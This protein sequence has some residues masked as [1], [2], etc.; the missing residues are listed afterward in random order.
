MALIKIN[1]NISYIPAVEE[2]LSCDV[3]FIKTNNATWI[4]D[5]GTNSEDFTEI[6]KIT[7][8][9]NIVISHFHYDHIFNLQKLDYT[10]L[11]VSKNTKKYSNDGVIVEGQMSFEN[12][13]EIKIVELPSS[14]AKGCLVL[15]YGDYA[16]LGDGAYC[17]PMLG[18]HTYNAQLLLEMIK[19]LENL[20]VKYFCL[21]HDKNFIQRKESV[22]ALYKA[23]YKRHEPNNPIINVED[24]F[25][26]DGS[27]KES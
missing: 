4:F 23:I 21:S 26:S 17:K 22:I 3:V 19:T 13:P 6:Q 24:F 15:V 12:D 8:T 5:T 14:H 16:F 9:K 27:V 2:P 20:D 10:N 7:G 25:N 11:Y 1:D 18:Q